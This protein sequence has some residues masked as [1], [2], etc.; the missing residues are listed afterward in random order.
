MP[1]E[2]SIAHRVRVANDLQLIAKVVTN[3]HAHPTVQER[4]KEVAK[5]KKGEKKD[6]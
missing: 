2:Q 1:T 3:L 5:E 6:D 4:L